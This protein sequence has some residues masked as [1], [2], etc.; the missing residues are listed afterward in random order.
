[1]ARWEQ[2]RRSL[3]D[4]KQKDRQQQ[5]QQQI[6]F[7]DDK[8]RKA[9]VLRHEWLQDEAFASFAAI[10]VSLGLGRA[11]VPIRQA[12]CSLPACPWGQS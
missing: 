9:T 10:L 7:G 1:M 4:D 6:P 3:P 12:E 11:P 8:A 2:H 5:I